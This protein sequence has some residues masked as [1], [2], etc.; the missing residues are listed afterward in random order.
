MK[1]IGAGWDGQFALPLMTLFEVPQ[2]EPEAT[3]GLKLAPGLGLRLRLEG[4]GLRY[5][6]TRQQS[7]LKTFKVQYIIA[8][9]RIRP[10]RPLGLGWRG[11]ES[12]QP[13][14]LA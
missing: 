9:S 6:H 7:L 13:L 2:I 3:V 4:G 12:N 14:L 1:A 5:N 10:P 8:K 11:G